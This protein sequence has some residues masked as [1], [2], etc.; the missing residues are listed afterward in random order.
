MEIKLLYKNLKFIEER[1][2]LFWT[3][4]TFIAGLI[5]L[6][7]TRIE[8]LI[9]FV[10]SSVSCT[11]FIFINYRK[12]FKESVWNKANRDLTLEFLISLI[13]LL[14]VLFCLK[15]NIYSEVYYNFNLNFLFIF[16][17]TSIFFSFKSMVDRYNFTINDELTD[18]IY[19]GS[20]VGKLFYSPYFLSEMDRIFHQITF[21]V[22]GSGKTVSALYPQIKHDIRTGKFVVILEPKGD[23]TFRDY[24]YSCC[25]KYNRQ[26]KFVSI[27]GSSISSGYNPFGFGDANAVKDK[28]MSSTDWSEQFYK[29]VSDTALSKALGAIDNNNIERSVG[30][31][32]FYLENILGL[33]P[34]VE[35]LSGLRAFLESLKYSS[36][37]S[38]FNESSPTLYDFFKDRV[39][40]FVSLDSLMYPE[41]SSSLGRIILQDMS[42]L[43][44]HIIA[45]IPEDKRPPISL[46][47]DEMA[48]F[49]SDNFLPFLSQTR[50]GNIRVTMACQSPADFSIHKDGVLARISDNTSTKIIMASSDPDSAEYLARLVG[51]R[52]IIKTTKQVDG[53]NKSET[54]RGSARDAHE[55][56]LEPNKIKRFQTGEAFIYV[57]SS[58]SYEEVQLD[59][60]FYDDVVIESYSVDYQKGNFINAQ[61][62]S[63]PTPNKLHSSINNKGEKENGNNEWQ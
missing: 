44:G 35:N 41:V 49:Y 52:E 19:V 13:V 12:M 63:T 10:I 42:T 37:A 62:T 61:I 58:L 53:D 8:Y 15:N 22:T 3:I 60:I 38:M 2:R 40:L 4:V 34:D 6:R 55:F 43:N 20:L 9:Q 14:G 48:T 17:G 24:V 26:F 47:I 1:Y 29:K 31:N 50:S 5:Y 23:N 28:I 27:A 30:R 56:I 39:V 51:T 54:G 57:R 7:L 59:T 36:F 46:Y 32:G 21:G 33:L 16:V 18:K 11:F 45:T 25:K